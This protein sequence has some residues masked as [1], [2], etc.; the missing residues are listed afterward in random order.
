MSDIQKE[1]GL[2]FVVDHHPDNMRLL[3]NILA[4]NGYDVRS[5]ISGKQELMTIQSV[6]PD[7]VLLNVQLPELNAFSVCKEIKNNDTTRDISVIFISAFDEPIDR[8]KAFEVGAADYITKPFVT[9]EILVRVKT[10]M[11]ISKMKKQLAFQNKQIQSIIADK[12]LTEHKFQKIQQE[13]DIRVKE[14]THDLEI[15]NERLQ[16]EIQQIR[17][18]QHQIQ[19]VQ[20]QEAIGTLAGGIAHD[21]NNILT[22]IHTCSQLIMN[23]LPQEHSAYVNIEKILKASE[24]ASELINQILTFSRKHQTA[25]FSP[26]SVVPIVE[27]AILVLKSG[28]SNHISLKTNIEIDDELISGNAKQIYQVIMNLCT[29]AIHAMETQK[30]GVL[31]ISLTQQFISE[32]QLNQYIPLHQ[33]KHIRLTVKDTGEGIPPSLMEKIFNPYY[34]TKGKGRGTGLGLA[35]T[36]GIVVKHK[37]MIHVHSNL[38]QGTKIDVFFPIIENDHAELI[39]KEQKTVIKENKRILL[40]DD[41]IDLLQTVQLL[42]EHIGYKVYAFDSPIK[43]L[44]A[45]EKNP[46]TFDLVIADLTMPEMNGKQVTKRIKKI[47]N[48]L[49]VIIAS[50][51]N[52]ELSENEMTQLNINGFLMKPFLTKELSESISQFFLASDRH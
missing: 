29:N 34:T 44:D 28:L 16:S 11:D 27:E 24:K 37:G 33:G 19:D 9:E 15:I 10:Q 12:K 46:D 30:N 35:V 26:I 36:L 45:F 41:E 31:S 5:A 40:I 47:R 21:F 42:L 20:K 50:G 17:D 49:P 18:A 22:I 14:K 48:D 7:L 23:D 1:K 3:K 25:L 38:N 4:E 32:D 13:L 51:N 43:A 2:V 6:L 39:S 52:S 8:I